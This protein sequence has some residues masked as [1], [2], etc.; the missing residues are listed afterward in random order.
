M[1]GSNFDANFGIPQQTFPFQGSDGQ[2]GLFAPNAAPD[3]FADP[4]GAGSPGTPAATPA[5]PPAAS[6]GVAPVA[7]H[8]TLS[9][10]GGGPL[11]PGAG[12]PNQPAPPDPSQPAPAAGI[13]GQFG[14]GK[15]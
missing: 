13:G 1:F 11:A 15:L 10:L 12:T 3:S 14:P 8:P 2:G 5:V 9:P 6:L 7:P 4:S